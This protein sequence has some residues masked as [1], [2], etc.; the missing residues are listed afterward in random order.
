[1]NKILRQYSEFLSLKRYSK[2]TVEVYIHCFK[3]FLANFKDYDIDNLSKNTLRHSFDT[4]LLEQG[5]D[6]C[7]IREL[8]GHAGSKTTGIYTYVIN[9]GGKGLRSPADF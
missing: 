6:L 2:R 5:T 7:Y 3:L 8:L 4:H 9:Q 1:M